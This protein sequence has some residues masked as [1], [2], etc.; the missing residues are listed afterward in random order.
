[1]IHYKNKR[2]LQQ[3]QELFRASRGEKKPHVE[4]KKIQ[5]DCGFSM[6]NH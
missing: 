2:K 6:R 3:Q 4:E 5:I 1:M